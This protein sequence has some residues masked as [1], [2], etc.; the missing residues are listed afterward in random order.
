[1]YFY[2]YQA[3]VAVDVNARL[4]VVQGCS[5]WTPLQYASATGNSDMAE[6]LIELGALPSTVF[7]VG[8]GLTALHIAS[9]FGHEDIVKLLL[10]SKAETNSFDMVLICILCYF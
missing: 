9:R 8:D 6:L 3:V 2:N 5:A 10:K 7:N 1:M 4:H